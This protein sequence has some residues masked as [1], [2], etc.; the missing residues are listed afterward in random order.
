[1]ILCGAATLGEGDGGSTTVS[2]PWDFAAMRENCPVFH[3]FHSD[4][5][6]FIPVHEA[7]RVKD[8][9]RLTEG[10]EFRLLKGRSHF[11]DAPF[12]ELLDLVCEMT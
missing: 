3:Q 9:L 11:F 4:N 6:P 12:H 7:Q 8:G 10:E 2:N 5:D 1:M